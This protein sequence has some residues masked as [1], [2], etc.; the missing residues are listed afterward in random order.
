ML[1]AP[2][3]PAKRTAYHHGDLRAA[4]VRAGLSVLATDGLAALTLRRVAAVVGVSHT[5]PKNHF[6]SVLALR[7]ALA[8]EGYW[9]L[10]QALKDAARAPDPAPRLADTFLGF[11]KK[12]AALFRL[13]TSADL[14]DASDTTLR[15]ASGAARSVVAAAAG[16]VDIG[17]FWALIHGAALLASLGAASVDMT[18]AL[19]ALGGADQQPI[20]RS[21]SPVSTSRHLSRAAK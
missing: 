10:A 20:S 3:L 14:I 19:R 21:A 17:A 11:A 13:M 4:L 15:E 5:A 18:A 12:D 16:P 6:D 7:T 1:P 2:S 8:T 9:R